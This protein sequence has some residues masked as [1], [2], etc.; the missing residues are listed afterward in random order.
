MKMCD[1]DGIN[2]F[3]VKRRVLRRTSSNIFVTLINVL[4]ERPMM[5]LLIILRTYYMS[6]YVYLDGER[7]AA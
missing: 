1:N 7:A 4:I 3:K 5:M 6:Y 2:V